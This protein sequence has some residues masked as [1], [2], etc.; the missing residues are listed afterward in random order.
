MATYT[1]RALSGSSYGRNI[2]VNTTSHSTLTVHATG[3][4]GHTD[5]IWLYATNISTSDIKLTT[6][7][8]TGG[9]TNHHSELTIGAEAGW[10]LVIPG[11][12]LDS[13]GGSCS[14]FAFAD[15]ANQVSLQGYVNRIT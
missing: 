4:G 6:E 9:A 8:G 15:T 11:F 10:V 14:V 2:L 12:I 7:F 3:T 5:E 1:K 13:G